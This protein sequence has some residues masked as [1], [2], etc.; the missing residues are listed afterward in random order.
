[1]AT[2][3]TSIDPRL[4]Q[5]RIAVRRAEGRRRLRI[6]LAAL[7]LAALLAGAYAVTRSALLDLD[8]VEVG[9][10]FG[11]EADE[12]VAATGLELGTPLLDLD[13]ATASDA[14]VA[15]PWVQTAEVSRAWPGTVTVDVVRRLPVALL[16]TGDGGGVIIDAEGIAIARTPSAAVGDLPVITVT[17]SGDLG[18]VQSFALPAIAVIE[19][20]PDD[21]VPWIET[22]AIEYDGGE[23]AEI[24]LDLVGS[25]TAELGIGTDVA[26]KLDALR[27]VLGRVELSCV[28]VIDVRIA[29]LPLV[30]DCDGDPAES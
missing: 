10:A 30:F 9:G 18:D 13:L 27:T 2:M 15:L 1:M 16:P 29:E 5:R 24:V 21:L 14:V 22:Y 8:R 25:A 3:T 23:E 26:A 17:A 28:S 6:L 20:V 7:G 4:R 12:V 19:A 11:S